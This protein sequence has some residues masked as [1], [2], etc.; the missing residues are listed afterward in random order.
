MQGRALVEALT[1]GGVAAGEARPSSH[2]V[3]TTD[4]AYEATASFSTLRIGGVE[5]RYFDG[6]KATR[7][8]R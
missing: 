4:G 3:R 7:K 5:Y 6:A 8:V 1:S 2:T